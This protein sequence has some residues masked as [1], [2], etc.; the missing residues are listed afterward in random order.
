MTDCG[1]SSESC[2]TSLEVTGGTYYRT[3]T[4]TG[5]SPTG[6]ADPAT[7]S[8]FRLDK[9]L[10]TVGRFRQFVSAVY[11]PPGGTR[12]SP[13]P[14]SGKHTHL[15]GGMGLLNVGGDDG[16]VEYEPG[17]VMS[18]DAY[19]APTNANLACDTTYPSWTA[20]AASNEDIPVNCVTWQEAYA[21]CIWDGGFLP[22]EAER[23]YAQVG[24][25]QQLEYPW[26][27]MDPG[28]SN[29]Y[30]IYNCYYPSGMPDCVAGTNVAPVGTPALGA[31]FWGQLDL[32]GEIDE[33]NLDWSP[34]GGAWIDPCTDCADLASGSLRVCKFGSPTLGATFLAPTPAD[35]LPTS[36]NGAM[37]FRCARSP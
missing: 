31:G 6:E 12:W 17:W 9:Y 37:G 1:A 8:G 5:G 35:N 11:P 4:N 16:G 7:V 10:V 2:C 36:R 34:P 13:P 21:F 14:G 29:E 18:D 25:S 15:N 30:A 27:S 22:S 26:G 3:F 33:W 24:G 19:I 28:M 20:T 23:E 32:A